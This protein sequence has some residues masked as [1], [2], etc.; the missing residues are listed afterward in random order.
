[1]IE[2]PS[3]DHRSSVGKGGGATM[4]AVSPVQRCHPHS[5]SGKLDC[6]FC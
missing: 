4:A 2:R 1:M 3:P 6:T 5:S